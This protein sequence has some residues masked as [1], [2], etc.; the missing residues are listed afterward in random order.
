MIAAAP[1]P[2]STQQHKVFI[3]LLLVLIMGPA[4]AVTTIVWVTKTGSLGEEASLVL[5][6]VA[7]RSDLHPSFGAAL[8]I[9]DGNA[10][11]L[12]D[13]SAQIMYNQQ[14]RT[15]M[16]TALEAKDG[17]TPNN[18]TSDPSILR[19]DVSEASGSYFPYIWPPI[20]ALSAYWLLQIGIDF[21]SQYAMWVTVLAWCIPV[22]MLL[23]LRSIAH[24]PKLDLPKS[25]FG[26]WMWLENVLLAGRSPHP[27]MLL[28]ATSLW[29]Y[30]PTYLALYYGQLTPLLL[31][32]VSWVAYCLAS[33][34]PHPRTAGLGFALCILK[35]AYLPL[36]IIPLLVIQKWRTCLVS[37]VLGWACGFLAMVPYLGVEWPWAYVHFLLQIGQHD[38]YGAVYTTSMVNWRGFSYHIANVFHLQ[39]NS[40]LRPFL[41]T[42]ATAT[43]A[44]S[45]L[46][47]CIRLTRLKAKLEI[48]V[49]PTERRYVGSARGIFIWAIAIAISTLTAY[50][51]HV[52]DLVLLL[53][54]VWVSM[55]KGLKID[56][57]YSESVLS[58][59]ILRLLA[60]FAVSAIGI[61]LLETYMSTTPSGNPLFVLWLALLTV[62]IG[63]VLGLSGAVSRFHPSA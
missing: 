1:A 9:K 46:L 49:S 12:Y 35:P 42:T 36:M 23:I 19:T 4:S 39:S 28:L 40:A 20:V 33:G 59:W 62:F 24:P 61:C 57:A 15:S 60:V 44:A 3:A 51:N 63:S 48:T 52:Y 30:P 50:H 8:I 53:P 10:R 37:A 43:C 58:G 25:R 56:G 17:S 18:R 14:L 6:G 2:L 5:S 54:L 34:E 31:L 13:P 21:P 22:S 16:L 55:A 26:T 32:G 47:M 45:L 11:L 7:L 41:V 27:A 38:Q 29:L